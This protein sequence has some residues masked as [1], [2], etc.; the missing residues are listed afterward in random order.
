MPPKAGCEYSPYFDRMN[1]SSMTPFW[2]RWG[3]ADFAFHLLLLLHALPVLAFRWFPTLDGPG[4]LYNARIIGSLLGRDT[5]TGRFFELNPF[6]EPNWLG[7]AI[8]ASIMAIAPAHVA[9]RAVMLLYVL[10]LP[11][12]FRYA[13]G[14]MGGHSGWT[15][16]LIF[17]FIYCFTFRIGFLNFSLALPLLLF[18]LGLGHAHLHAPGPRSRWPLALLITTLYFAHLTCFLLAVGV[19][20]GMSVWKALTDRKGD[21][22]THLRSAWSTVRTFLICTA[23]AL[24]LTI[25]YF[26]SHEELRTEL[27]HLPMVELWDWLLNGRPFVALNSAEEPYARAFA[28]VMAGLI[29][30]V[31][32]Q[33]GLKS[34]RG[35][36]RSSWLVIVAIALVIAYFVLPDQMATGSMASVRLLL[37]AYLFLALWLGLQRFGRIVTALA[38]TVYITA[39]LLALRMHYQYTS[40]LNSELAELLAVAPSIAPN[41]V[42]VPLNYGTN[43]LHSNFACHLGARKGVIVADN[44]CAL[45][46]HNPVLWKDGM[47]P[48]DAIGTFAT[49]DR[50][51]VDLDAY[52]LQ[53][54]LAVDHVFTWK[55]ND[56]ITDSCTNDVRRQLA[57]AFDLVAVSPHGDARLYRRR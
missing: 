34:D 45:A 49:S 22:A 42:V 52:V 40:D 27:K 8:M 9:E 5:F 37:F 3:L 51:C 55:M 35:W 41:A 15:T 18:T 16:L 26:L 57:R 43:W 4:H 53:G 30:A 2:R 54:D 19:L 36:P 31:I 11:F 23:P 29:I 21:T 7:H 25:A 28:W 12:A 6:P 46:P 39:D 17:P 24:L 48:N 47:M 20:L 1:E 56:A 14:R 44:F 10:G 33:H 32:V 13:L 50:P 38:M